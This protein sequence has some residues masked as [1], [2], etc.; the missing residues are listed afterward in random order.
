MWARALNE[1]NKRRES[2]RADAYRTLQ[3]RINENFGIL[4]AIMDAKD[5]REE[6]RKCE[7]FMGEERGPHGGNALD[8]LSDFLNGKVN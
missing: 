8:E 7:E 3:F 4:T 1:F 2:S 6:A 5:L